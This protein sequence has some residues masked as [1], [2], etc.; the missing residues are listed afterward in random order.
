MK[1][2]FMCSPNILFLV[3][4]FLFA[5]FFFF[6]SFADVHFYL[7]GCSLLTASISHFLTA[8]KKLSCCFSKKSSSFFISRSSSFSVIY[9]SID[10]KGGSQWVGGFYGYRLKFWLF[11]GYR[12]ICFQLRLAK[13]LKI[14]LFRF[15]ELNVIIIHSKYFPHSDWLKTHA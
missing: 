10:I 6:F 13:K 14:N 5:F 12:L 11:Y 8:D 7:A 3:L 4:V 9:V 1:K 15:K 2:K